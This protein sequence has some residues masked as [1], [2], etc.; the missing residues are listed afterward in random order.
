[1]LY[2]LNPEGPRDE[3]TVSQ[4]SQVWIA[5][6]KKGTMGMLKQ[7]HHAWCYESPDLASILDY[8]LAYVS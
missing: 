1:M 3:S 2:Q 6:T 5:I 4:L 8:V 7:L